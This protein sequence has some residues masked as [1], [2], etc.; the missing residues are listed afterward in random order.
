LASIATTSVLRNDLEPGLQE[1]I[2]K[3]FL[4]LKDPAILKPLKA[5][6]LAEVEDKDYDQVRSMVKFLGI[7]LE[8]T[9]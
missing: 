9:R 6:G 2:K 8:K 5:E 7:D 1:S 3:A 4:S